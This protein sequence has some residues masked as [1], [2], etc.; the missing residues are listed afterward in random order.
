MTAR[1][2]LALALSYILGALTIIGYFAW[3]TV[4]P[5]FDWWVPF[6]RAFECWSR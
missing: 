5:A 3:W 4:G 2:V 6:E 1:T